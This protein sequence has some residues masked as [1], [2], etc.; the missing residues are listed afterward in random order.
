MDARITNYQLLP[1]DDSCMFTAAGVDSL[2]RT[3]S[4]GLDGRAGAHS[5]PKATHQQPP[6]P[7]QP[8]FVCHKGEGQLAARGCDGSACTHCAVTKYVPRAQRISA[9]VGMIRDAAARRGWPYRWFVYHRPD[10]W[11]F[12]LP[13]LADWERGLA[14]E[15]GDPTRSAY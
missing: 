8:R 15:R 13:K 7:P 9:C 4:D 3:Q 1:L 10:M 12:Y 2:E 6:A 5:R 14:L 11:L